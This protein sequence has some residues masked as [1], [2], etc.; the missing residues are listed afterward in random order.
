MLDVCGPDIRRGCAYRVSAKGGSERVGVQRP[1]F[2]RSL[3]DVRERFEDETAC[4]AYLDKVTFC[5][6]HPEAG[7]PNSS[8]LGHRARSIACTRLRDSEL[9]R[10]A[11]A[12]QAAERAGRRD[13]HPGQRNPDHQQQACNRSPRTMG[14]EPCR[15]A[16]YV[17]DS[18]F[19]ALPMDAARYYKARRFVERRATR[20]D[21]DDAD[22][23]RAHACG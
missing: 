15:H 7:R 13:G 4:R 3:H 6:T 22:R 5:V 23:T 9:A 12:M 18:P 2:P 10:S 19:Q 21:D 8:G 11:H 17:T 16:G 20:E 14:F 1:E